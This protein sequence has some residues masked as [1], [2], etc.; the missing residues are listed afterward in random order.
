MTAAT[1]RRALLAVTLAAAATATVPG[2][3]SSAAGAARSARTGGAATPATVDNRFWY[4]HAHWLAGTHHGTA[5]AEG[6][7]P[8]L[9]IDTP[10]GRT[11]YQDPHT[12]KKTTWEYATWTSRSTAPPY[13]PPR[14]SPPG[15]PAPRPAPGSRSS[16]APPTPTEPPAPGT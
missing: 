9:R 11:E 13:P 6:D 7:R 4:A 16:C 5:A 10:V 8:A 1:P 14:P 15:T 3:R 2:G 12:G